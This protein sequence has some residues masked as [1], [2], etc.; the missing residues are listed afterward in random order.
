MLRW[1][2]FIFIIKSFTAYG[3]QPQYD[4]PLKIPLRLAGNFC[5]V[6]PDHFH[7]GIDIKTNGHEGLPVYAVDDGYI[8]RV[9]IAS[10]GFGKVI[11]ITHPGNRLTVYAHLH[12]FTGS[13]A[14]SMETLQY[15]RK[16]FEV[17]WFPD[18]MLF[19]IQRGQQIAWSGNSGGSESPHLHFE[20]RDEQTEEPLN[21]LL[22]GF[23]IDDTIKPFIEKIALYEYKNGRYIYDKNLPLLKSEQSNIADTFF[24]N[25]DTLATAFLLYDAMNDS[26]PSSL[27]VFSVVLRNGNDT[28]YHY[29]FNK[30]SF[31]ETRNVNGYI[32][33]LHQRNQK[34]TLVRCYT[35][36]GNKFNAFRNAGKGYIILKENEITLLKIKV[37]DV[38][39]NITEYSFY[40]KNEKTKL[41]S[42]GQKEEN[43]V[44]YPNKEISV[45][46]PEANILI[47]DESLFESTAG[48]DFNLKHTKIN[49][50]VVKISPLGLTLSKRMTILF[51]PSKSYRKLMNK[52][53]IVE[54]AENGKVL[55]S[56]STS[57]IKKYISAS[58]WTFGNYTFTIDSMPPVFSVLTIRTDSIFN[59]RWLE[60]KVKDGLSGMKEYSGKINGEWKLFEYDGKNE[61]LAYKLK[62]EEMKFDLLLEASDQKGNKEIFSKGVEIEAGNIIK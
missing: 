43:V 38:N 61:T 28:V 55:R 59:E 10:D 20:I 45:K 21:P 47:P 26:L 25:Y 29:V 4:S 17:E 5:E 27:G 48:M 12:S 33:F 60:I 31:S 18:S 51:K 1:I 49:R 35:L 37:A 42:P 14:D 57:V 34:E 58:T 44:Y 3:Q 13:L 19:R 40:V 62:P 41:K 46:W 32:D 11:Y 36:P 50:P 52:L 30:M 15:K 24:V 22:N 2:I 9:K 56:L 54:L 53:V 7:S 23:H 39:N 16:S 6:R 8:S